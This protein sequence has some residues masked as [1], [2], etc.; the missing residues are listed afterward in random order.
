MF[1]LITWDGSYAQISG[2][3]INVLII[4]DGLPDLV[5]QSY[6]YTGVCG[7]V[8]HIM[9]GFLTLGKDS[10]KLT[11]PASFSVKTW[12]VETTSF[13]LQTWTWPGFEWRTWHFPDGLFDAP[14]NRCSC[15]YIHINTR[16]IYTYTYIYDIYYGDSSAVHDAIC[17]SI[18]F[19]ST[20]KQFSEVM[21]P[22][23]RFR[24]FSCTEIGSVSPFF[25]IQLLWN[26]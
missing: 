5:H 8:C 20:M 4:P 26:A 11:H 24:L 25:T 7:N 12:A 1:G 22:P 9:C 21:P 3:A 10:S 17:M 19:Y 16:Y 2:L 13:A 6:V 15:D 23:I 18:V 14:A